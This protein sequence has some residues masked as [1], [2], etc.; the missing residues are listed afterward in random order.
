MSAYAARRPRTRRPTVTPEQ[1][2]ARRREQVERMQHAIEDLRSSEGWEHWLQ[3]RV[4]F[5]RYSFANR[6]LIAQQCPDATQVAGF[7]TWQQLG[8]NVRK[9]EHGIGIWS[10]PFTVTRKRDTADQEAETGDDADTFQAYRIVY[11]FDVSQTDGEPLTRP[12]EVEVSGDSLAPILPRLEAMAARLGYTVDYQPLG[13]ELT[14]PR[15]W[16][17]SATK[18]IVISTD[19]SVNSQAKTLVHELA[20]AQGVGSKEYGRRDAEVIVESVAFCVLGLLGF[21]TSS[22]SVAYVANWGDANPETLRKHAE[23]VDE[24]IRS[25]EEMLGLDAEPADLAA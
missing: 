4:R 17:D 5:H 24:L 11:V 14:V 12:Q 20:H 16:C 9:G 1:R 6:L 19:A 18:Q 10:H 22:Y 8:R 23:T 21:D 3:A 15:G 7:K 2:A 25:F 13:D